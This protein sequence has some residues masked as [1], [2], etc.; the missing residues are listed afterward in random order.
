MTHV[1][2]THSDVQD[3]M[4]QATSPFVSRM[5]QK[6]T[7]RGVKQGKQAQDRSLVLSTSPSPK[8]HGEGGRVSQTMTPPQQHFPYFPNHSAVWSWLLPTAL[9]RS[10]IVNLLPRSWHIGQGPQTP[11]KQE[12]NIPRGSSLTQTLSSFAANC[13]EP[14]AAV[15]WTREQSQQPAA[16]LHQHPGGGGRKNSTDN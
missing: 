7:E 9:L 5:L 4:R 10:S 14:E 12:G 3:S 1:P 13:R 16:S 11:P 2:Q 6:G 15:G 8:P